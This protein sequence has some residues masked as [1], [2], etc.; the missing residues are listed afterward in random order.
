MYA[1]DHSRLVS[2]THLLKCWVLPAEYY[3]DT[4]S[5]FQS[6]YHTSPLSHEILSCMASEFL[7]YNWYQTL[8]LAPVTLL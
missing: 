8:C 7:K 4:G 2:T 6:P 5:C 1:I 3:Y